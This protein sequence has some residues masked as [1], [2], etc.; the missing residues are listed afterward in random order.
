MKQHRMSEYRKHLTVDQAV[1]DLMARDTQYREE[2]KKQVDQKL[3][4]AERKRNLE[5]KRRFITI[6]ESNR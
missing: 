2:L 1:E 4:S 5:E 3:D 6:S